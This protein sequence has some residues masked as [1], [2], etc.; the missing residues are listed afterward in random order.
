MKILNN[1]V[2]SCLNTES[3]K[4]PA[5]SNFLTRHA[6]PFLLIT[7]NSM[8][9]WI[10]S[11]ALSNTVH[12]SVVHKSTAFLGLMGWIMENRLYRRNKTHI[13]LETELK[14]Y[15]SR[16]QAVSTDALY[17]VM[18]PV[19][20]LFDG[21]FEDNARWTKILIL[22]ICPD[23]SCGVAQVELLALNSWGELFLDQLKLDTDR[24]LN[25]RY[26]KIADKINQYT[27]E[28]I[29][30]FFFQMTDTRDANAVYK[31]KQFL[32]DRFLMHRPGTPKKNRPMLDKL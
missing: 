22:L 16:D 24:P 29:R 18:Q 12:E 15:E 31:I 11:A 30:L 2:K 1:K 20:P 5:S 19:K 14:L 7:K 26:R 8:G 32:A 13:R 9:K 27:G 21:C 4:I 25:D 6:L 23:P 28:E 10:L 17:L 3:G